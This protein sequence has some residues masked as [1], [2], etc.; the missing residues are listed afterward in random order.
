MTGELV[1]L[2]ASMYLVQLTA[3]MYLVQLLLFLFNTSTTEL[4]YVYMNDIYSLQ[5]YSFDKTELSLCHKLLFS[6]PFIFAPQY[7]IP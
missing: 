6:N 2:T 4:K 7:C 3:S 1:Q 5:A